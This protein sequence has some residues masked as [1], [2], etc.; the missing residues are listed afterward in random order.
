MNV[1]SVGTTETIPGAVEDDVNDHDDDIKRWSFEVTSIAVLLVMLCVATA[2]LIRTRLDKLCT[3]RQE[4]QIMAEVI[5]KH[6]A[7]TRLKSA[8]GSPSSTRSDTPVPHG[9]A[10]ASS[11]DS[12]N[13]EPALITRPNTM[14][15][16]HPQPISLA[17]EMMLRSNIAIE[18]EERNQRVVTSASPTT[19]STP[20]VLETPYSTSADAPGLS[21]N[22]SAGL[23]KQ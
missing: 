13:P 8:K 12:E 21:R 7:I 10:T 5:G 14:Q 6:K 20:P 3:L 19:T 2:H 1:T 23:Y 9:S 22:W 15:C 16:T 4:E 18:C 11:F 17:A